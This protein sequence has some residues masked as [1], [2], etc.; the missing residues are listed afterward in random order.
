MTYKVC[1]LSWHFAT[2]EV[3]LKSILKMTPG[4][5]GKWG[6]IEAVTDPFEADFCFIMDGYSGKF[7]EERAIYFGEH[8]SVC[9][10]SYRTWQD[11]KAL[12]RLSLDKHL[13][14]GEW[15]LGLDYDH[16]MQ[17]ECP[18]KPRR[19]ACIMT[20]QTHNAM[21]A[22]RPKFMQ[23]YVT[24]YP[25]SAPDIY[26]RPEERFNV[27]EILKPYYHGALG[28]NHPDGRIGEHLIGKEV[29]QVYKYSLEFD[30]GPTKN[31]FSERFYDALLLWTCPIYFGSTNVASY[32][33]FKSFWNIDIND[34]EDIDRVYNIV[35]GFYPDYEA[36][37]EARDLLLNKYQMWAYA[38]DVVN[39]LDR[40]TN[41]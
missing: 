34:L 35:A 6:N 10:T 5:S 13:N 15:W 19:L 40:Y 21:Y 3:F 14:L 26:G 29:L 22:Q 41:L 39:N 25:H 18:K 33:P 2:P 16:L 24:R 8:P 23:E 7:P 32:I 36:I 38:H 1:W 9:E 17:L 20:Y 30:V 27:D 28:F 4:R 12:A 37:K 11:K 31:Y